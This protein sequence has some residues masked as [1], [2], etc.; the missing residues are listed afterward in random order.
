[1]SNTPP[2]SI[3]Y[4]TED[5]ITGLKCCT[6]DPLEEC[7]ACPFADS[8]PRCYEVLMKAALERIEISSAVISKLE[9]I[10]NSKS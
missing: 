10:I 9:D 4:P 8:G 3:Q 1:M 6:K 2:L 5:V 7:E